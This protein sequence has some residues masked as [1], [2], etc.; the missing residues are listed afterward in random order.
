MHWWGWEQKRGWPHIL[1]MHKHCFVKYNYPLAP[2]F[3]TC[4]N[5]QELSSLCGKFPDCPELT[6][7][8]QGRYACSYLL[9]CTY[10]TSMIFHYGGNMG[11]S[12]SCLYMIFRLKQRMMIDFKILEGNLLEHLYSSLHSSVNQRQRDMMFPE[13]R[14]IVLG[15]GRPFAKSACFQVPKN[16]T[17]SAKI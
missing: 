1:S 10:N 3:E 4:Q 6:L 12:N 8:N 5:V 11:Q 9:T 17:S 16:G 13:E 7:R 15:P 2:S 14:F